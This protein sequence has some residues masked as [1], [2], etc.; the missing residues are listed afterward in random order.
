MSKEILIKKWTEENKPIGEALG[1]P[2]CCIEQ[3]CNLPPQLMKGTPTPSDK[4]RLEASYLNG[5]YTGFIPCTEHAKQIIEG[6]ITLHS[7]IDKQKRANN[8]EYY[9]PEFPN[10]MM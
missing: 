2:A 5:V 9:I 1:Y 7:L 10:A 6:K 3:F 8:Q 4:L